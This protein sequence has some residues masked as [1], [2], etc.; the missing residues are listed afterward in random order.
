MLT[1]VHSGHYPPAYQCH[2]WIGNCKP[3]MK[4]PA[5]QY[6]GLAKYSVRHFNLKRIDDVTED[7]RMTA[8]KS[9]SH[10]QSPKIIGATPN[11]WPLWKR[12]RV[13]VL[14]LQHPHWLHNILE[15]RYDLWMVFYGENYTSPLFDAA[16]R[17][18]VSWQLCYWF[19][20]ELK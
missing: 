6:H 10:F 15:W 4:G 5:G 18:K 14:A 9:P 17:K 2:C 20:F 11:R 16:Y 13:L 19:T 3:D 12:L 8:V 7:Y 1:R